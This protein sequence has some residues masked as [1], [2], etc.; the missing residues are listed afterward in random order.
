MDDGDLL[1]LSGDDVRGFLK[2]RE[3]E[4]MEAV[5][6]AY[7]AHSEGRTEL[8]HSTFLRFPGQPRDRIIA[9]PAYLG[10]DLPV[11][12]I[13][14][15]SS[16]PGNRELG[17]ER[18]SAL[19]ILNST[20][21][22]RPHAVLEG[23]LINAR[24]TAASA[25]VAALSLCSPLPHPV[26]AVIGCGVINHEVVRFLLKARP[27]IQRLLVH[28]LDRDR[29]GRFAAEWRRRRPD[30]QAEV[31]DCAG[32]LASARLVSIA[33]TALEPHIDDLS[34]CPAGTTILHI[35]LRDLSPR[36]ILGCVNITDDA[37]HVCRA[38][39]SLH[40]AEQQVGHREFISAGLGDV[41]RGAATGRPDADAL[42]VFSP[43]GLGILDL[44]VARLV[45]DLAGGSGRGS[46]LRGFLSGA[47]VVA[48]GAPA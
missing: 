45:T 26:L 31:V 30:L 8:P 13:K 23:S 16:F 20:L 38:E 43:F 33:T 19:V 36:A 25:A 42:V 28:D 6:A 3:A 18:A 39:T 44:A 34:A 5:A 35:S 2:G 40:L 11:A 21:T 1:I 32:A 4:L 37:D 9:L 17:L 14:W 22:G 29:A 41:L 7:R 10:G 46:L 12:G 15:V 48:A 27:G 24:R 47:P